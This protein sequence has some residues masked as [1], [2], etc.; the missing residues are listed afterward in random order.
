MEKGHFLGGVGPPHPSQ[1]DVRQALSLET[2]GVALG[3]GGALPRLKQGP[4][5]IQFS[6]S[7]PN[8]K[9]SS[10]YWFSAKCLQILLGE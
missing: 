8:R 7:F 4:V 5:F 3:L 2:T 10:G 9:T 1:A 6:P